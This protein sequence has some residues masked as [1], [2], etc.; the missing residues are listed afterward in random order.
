MKSMTAKIN[1]LKYRNSKL[2]EEK[3]RLLQSGQ[4]LRDILS[5]Q[6]IT[7]KWGSCN[8]CGKKFGTEEDD[9]GPFLLE[10]C[11]AVSNSID[12][13][14]PNILISLLAMVLRLYQSCRR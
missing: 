7:I 8:N 14:Q 9:T 1:S 2:E 5:S 13:F 12:H 3:K 4:E 11:G 6:P 10:L